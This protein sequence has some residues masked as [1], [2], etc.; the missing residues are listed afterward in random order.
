LRDASAVICITPGGR[1]LLLGR[2]P[3][4]E[5]GAIDKKICVITSAI[6]TAWH[7]PPESLQPSPTGSIRLISI[8]D[9]TRNKNVRAVIDAAE[10]LSQRGVAV[11]L[12]LV[13]GLRERL[14]I[15]LPDWVR[16]I[17]HVCDK[18]AL[19]DLVRTQDVFVM[20]SFAETFGLAYVEALSQGV[21]V[22]HSRGQAVEGLFTEGIVS[23][24][25]DPRS[26]AE[27]AAAIEHLSS[28]RTRNWRQC[29]SE[30]LRF[31]WNL[32]AEQLHGVYSKAVTTSAT[33]SLPR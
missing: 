24:G 19:R 15:R 7:E 12:T 2:L 11:E 17:P 20:P 16:Y 21:P 29:I 6:S 30:T 3:R 1:D 14:P 4:S 26:P 9:M 13:G 18:R 23:M 28:G 10:I 25:V 22:V 27:I 5:R 31:R 8:S 33:Q 32:V